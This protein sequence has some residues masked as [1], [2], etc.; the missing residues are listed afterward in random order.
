M[1]EHQRAGRNNND[2]RPEQA[3][4][5]ADAIPAGHRD[6]AQQL[7]LDAGLALALCGVLVG[8]IP[9]A[10]DDPAAAD[11][12]LAFIGFLLWIAGACLC[13]LALTPAAPRAVIMAAAS[14]VLVRCACPLLASTSARAEDER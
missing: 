10:F 5:P 4:E 14:A 12:Q 1:A 6:R 13:L 11:A 9:P 2:E 3:I 8:T 7:C